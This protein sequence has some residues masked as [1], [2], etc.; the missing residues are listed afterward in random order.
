MDDYLGM[1]GLILILA[2]WLVEFYDVL[3]KRVDENLAAWNSAAGKSYRVSISIGAVA[4]DQR[5]SVSLE[6]LLGRADEALYG[7]KKRKKEAKGAP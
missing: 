1:L 4:F 7:E 5:A 3:R 2:G 6:E